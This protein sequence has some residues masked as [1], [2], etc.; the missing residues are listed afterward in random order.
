VVGYVFESHLRSYLERNARRSGRERV[1]DRALCITLHI[2]RAPTLT[3]GFDRVDRVR[4]A[5]D[6]MFVVEG[7]EGWDLAERWTFLA[8]VHH[9]VHRT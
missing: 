4:L 7:L 9:K 3:E 1:P 5:P 6:G 8:K 2:L